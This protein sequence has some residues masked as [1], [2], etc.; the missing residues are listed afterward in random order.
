[1]TKAALLGA[2]SLLFAVGAIHSSLGERR[3]VGPLLAPERRHGLLEK[4]LFARQVLRFAWHL[5]TV[6][7]W[8]FA[9]VLAAIALSPMGGLGRVVPG[10][11]AATF[12]VT[13]L[14]T[15]AATRGHHL[16][17]PVFL[18]IAALSLVPL[19]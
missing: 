10:I 6:A 2:A 17:W 4:S 19:L 3:L 16:A 1:M 12:L 11:V 13:G 8:G 7:W 9:A 18:L 5:T 15:L 14:A